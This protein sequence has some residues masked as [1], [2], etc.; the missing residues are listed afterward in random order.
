V[1]LEDGARNL[2]EEAR[3]LGVEREAEGLVWEKERTR[4]EVGASLIR[5]SAPLGPYSRTMSGAVW[6]P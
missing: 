5:V 3:N 4:L 2:E 6:W 1:S